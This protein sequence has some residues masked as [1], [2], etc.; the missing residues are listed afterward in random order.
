MNGERGGKKSLDSQLFQGRIF[1]VG[2][3]V[4]GL[5]VL[6]AVLFGLSRSNSAGQFVGI[7]ASATAIG[8]ASGAV[9]ALLGFLFGIPKTPQLVNESDDSTAPATT[10]GRYLGNTSLEQMS[11]WLTKIIVGVSLVQIGKLG[12]ALGDLANSLG[13]MLGDT[14]ESREGRGFGLAMALFSLILGFLLVYL[15]TRVRLKRE[16][17]LAD[18]E[19]IALQAASRTDEAVSAINVIAQ[20]LGDAIKTQRTDLKKVKGELS[21]VAESTG[22][23]V[24]TLTQQVDELSK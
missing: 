9:G 23:A 3:W 12:P 4:T 16:M 22:A 1:R 20:K 8:L 15:W 13:S 11:D 10:S 6:L 18:V 2:G 17:E 19:G 21:K 24:A 14:A 7:A 5:F